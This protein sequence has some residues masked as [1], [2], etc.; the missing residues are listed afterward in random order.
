MF[1]H[2][3][4]SRL[5]VFT[6]FRMGIFGGCSRMGGSIKVPL[7]KICRTYPNGETWHSYLKE[8]QKKYESRDTPTEFYW[9]QNK[10]IQIQIAFWY[11]IFNSF[12]FSSVFKDFLINLV[13]ILRMSA[14]IGTPGLLKLTI[15]WRHNSCQ[16]RQQHNFITRFKSY[17]RCV[18]VTKVW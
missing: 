11:I 10:Q 4:F 6:L 7:P 8:I 18:H 3:N 15:F 2:L 16:W 13:I 9:H 5:Y 12:N 17:C 14:K 1:M